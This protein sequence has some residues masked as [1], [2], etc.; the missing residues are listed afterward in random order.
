MTIHRIFELSVYLSQYIFQLRW[1]LCTGIARATLAWSV[2]QIL[3]Y[4]LNLLLKSTLIFSTTIHSLLFSSTIEF[5]R[6]FLIT[7]N[8]KNQAV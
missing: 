2:S 5:G 8:R 6:H 3:L 4:S 1:K 7:K